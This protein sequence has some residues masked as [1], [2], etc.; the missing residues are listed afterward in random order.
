MQFSEQWLREW[1]NPDINTETLVAQL[2]MAGLEVDSVQPV[3]AAF[4][5]VF[6]G[7]VLSVE[8]HPDA[9][10]LRVCTVNVAPVKPEPLTIVCGAPNVSVGMKIPVAVVGA[11]LPN[12]KIKKAKLRGQE[13][14]GMLCSKAELGLAESADGLMALPDDAPVGMDI[15]EFLQL[16]DSIID[17][18][19]TPNRGDC[20][21]IAGLAREVGV[22][23]RCDVSAPSMPAIDPV[24]DDL[25]AVAL[26]APEHCPHYVGRVL[27]NIDI[28]KIS[29]IWLVE[30]LRR[31]GIRSI[32]PVVD[33]TNYVLLELGQPMHAFDLDQLQ[34]S[35]QV[36]LADKNEKLILL[37][38]QT[39]E[40]DED[41]LVIADENRALAMA[42]VMGGEASGVTE[43]SRHIFLESAYF[44]PIKIAGKA[45]S[46]GLHTDSSHRFERGVDYQLQRQAIERA[47]ALLLDIVGGEPGPVNEVTVAASMPASQDIQL[48]KARIKRVL[49]FDMESNEVEDILTRLGMEC[50]AAEADSWQVRVPSYRFDITVEEDLLE[51][52]GRI[53]GYD[54][55]PVRM[56]LAAMQFAKQ[57]ETNVP[58]S[59]VRT[60]LAD[61]DYQEA[62][63]YSFVDPELQALIDPDTAPLKLANPISAEMSV[64]RTSLWPGLLKAMIHNQNRQQNR[65][66]LFEIGTRFVPTGDGLKQETVLSGVVK[67]PRDQ[68]GWSNNKQSVD[69]Y[70]IKGDL[71][72]VL[73]LG[74]RA[75]DWQFQAGERLALHPGRCANILKNGQNIGS[76]GELHPNIQR[77]LQINGSIYLFELDLFE[78]IKG[79]LPGFTELSKFPEVKRDIA[80]IVDESINAE[81]AI[82]CV[83][84]SGGACLQNVSVFD[85]YQGKGIDPGKKSLALT[86][87]FQHVSRTLNES[88]INEQ[89]GQVVTVLKHQLNA[90]LRD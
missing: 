90:I 8:Q 24:C 30:K 87:T 38:G 55:L 88:E 65:I 71:E 41:T 16:D 26:Q 80:I 19:L 82:K 17:L 5:Q 13:S 27:R 56:P 83:Q 40:L 86:M 31:S 25:F 47:T 52:L 70:D 75:Q 49:G 51:E 85:V 78:M 3:A 35:I 89:L 6:V 4:N 34:G 46:H 57:S 81:Q 48:R 67:G 53:Y 50:Q 11:T 45:R 1:V 64:M 44:S 66:R 61:L 62:I 29:P 10:K 42:G 22:L 14:F 54:N 39:L 32:D 84:A 9:D 28:N 37:D 33:V 21:G 72:T 23:N 7:Q 59:R 68:E 20:L 15:R 79:V 63:T 58:I 69:F 36:R 2:T 18:D 73:G 60:C 76:I 74:G 43:K 77:E 12:F